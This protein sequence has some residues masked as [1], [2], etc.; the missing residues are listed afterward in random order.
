[1]FSVTRRLA[2]AALVLG[3]LAAS[4]WAADAPKVKFVTSAGEIVVEVYPDKAPKTAENFLQYVKDKHYDGT[5]FH[6]VIPMGIVQGGDPL[7]KDPRPTAPLG[8]GGLGV[9]QAEHSA[10]PFTRG[11]VGA[12]LR[13]GQPDSGG[14]QFFVCVT[15]QPALAGQF[16][17]FARVG[18]VKRQYWMRQ[19]AV[20]KI[21][22]EGVI[23]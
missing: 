20:W 15:D 5:V 14:A 6:R 1:M 7:S 10:E 9:L 8:S 13:P 23:G 21:F 19:G 16:T 11:V 12:A 18:P 3:C 4:A 17:V 2:A 22:F